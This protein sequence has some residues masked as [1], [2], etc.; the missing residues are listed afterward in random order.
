MR[1]TKKSITNHSCEA[2]TLGQRTR[3][4]WAPGWWQLSDALLDAK[5]DSALNKLSRSGQ[6][7]HTVET[8]VEPLVNDSKFKARVQVLQH[9]A[10]AAISG[11]R[12]CGTYRICSQP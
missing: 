7:R 8:K 1:P 12:S 4:G 6:P 11:A 5:V 3:Q 9:A 2:P 10:T